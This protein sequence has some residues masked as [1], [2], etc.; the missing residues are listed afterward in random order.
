MT[1]H[2]TT[3]RQSGTRVT[4]VLDGAWIGDLPWQA[5]L[6]LAEALRT[7][8]KRAEEWDKAS[9]IAADQAVLLRAGIPLGLTS[10]PTIQAEA[11]KLAA[12]D[13]DLR[14]YLPGG[15]RS[16]AAVGTP[17]IRQSARRCTQ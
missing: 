11:A 16:Q 12:W 4:L 17:S 13:R 7:Q 15:V 5:A 10:H 8:A 6:D 1:T 3:V 2:T 14:R 9:K